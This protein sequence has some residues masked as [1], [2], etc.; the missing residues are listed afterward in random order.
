MSPKPEECL[1]FNAQNSIYMSTLGTNSLGEFKIP[2]KTYS[3]QIGALAAT[4]I[5]NKKVQTDKPQTNTE[6]E[7]STCKREDHLISMTMAYWV[8][9]A[10]EQLGPNPPRPI[11]S[12]E[13]YRRIPLPNST[14]NNIKGN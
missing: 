3:T 12:R 5:K 8:K 9:D 1:T 11:T 2:R 14:I 10:Q 4:K 6:T 7:C 13:D